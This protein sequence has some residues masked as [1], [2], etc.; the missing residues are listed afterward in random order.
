[1]RYL[2]VLVVLVAGCAHAPK[3]EPTFK[4]FTILD[5]PPTVPADTVAAVSH[6]ATWGQIKALYN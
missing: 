4:P 3:A 6:Q 1:M 5:A 2:I